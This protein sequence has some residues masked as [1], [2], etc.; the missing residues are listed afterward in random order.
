MCVCVCVCVCS[1][2]C[3]ER[4]LIRILVLFDIRVIIVII[5]MAMVVIRS[6]L[7]YLSTLRFG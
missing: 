7:Q 2:V 1:M 4:S 6:V 3:G 5:F